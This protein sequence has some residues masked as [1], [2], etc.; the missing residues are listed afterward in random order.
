V[1]PARAIKLNR[2][3]SKVYMPAQKTEEPVAANSGGKGGGRERD[4]ERDKEVL[5]NVTGLHRRGGK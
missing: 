4:R 5:A 3:G 1:C 2:P